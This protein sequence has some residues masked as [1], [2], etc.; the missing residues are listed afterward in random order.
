MK[1]P[2]AKAGQ[3]PGNDQGPGV[4]VLLIALGGAALLAYIITQQGGRTLAR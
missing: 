4:G 1:R 2:I 3:S